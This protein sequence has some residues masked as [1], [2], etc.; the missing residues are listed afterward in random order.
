MRKFY[1]LW[2]ALGLL[3][4]WVWCLPQADPSLYQQAKLT[5]Q[6]RERSY[7]VHLPKRYD[8]QKK[9]PMLLLF[10]GGGGSAPQ[11]LDSYPLLEVSDREGFILVAANGSGR[12]R[13]EILRTWNVGFGFG[14]AQ[15]N[16]VDDVGF[17]RQL[18]L[19]LSKDY[20]V[21]SQRVFLTGLS[22]GA[23]LSHQ[24]GAANSDLVA[25]IA[26]VA[27]TV[28]GKMPGEKSLL[29]PVTPQKP[30]DVILFHGSQ[31]LSLPLE[32]GVQKRHA[33]EAPREVASARESAEFW[34]QANGCSMQPI[35]E[36]LAAQKATRYSWS[37]GK[38]R[39]VLYVLHNQGHAW[40]GGKVPRIQADVP[41][42]LLKAHDLMWDFFRDSRK[43]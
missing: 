5:H 19:K 3:V 23:I 27:G 25:G 18:I 37:G 28:A 31:D 29:Y 35:V 17:V 7:Y 20:A 4:S 13:Q 24:A 43:N 12:I 39:V 41:S 33:E 6:G 11:A 36:E 2:L 8:P 15:K 34:A 26:P 42:Q 16:Q 22:N 40:P 30:V 10:H 21:D 32:G 1:V 38:A 9:W 14:Y